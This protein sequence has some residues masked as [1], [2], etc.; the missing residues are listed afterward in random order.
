MPRTH[1]INPDNIPEPFHSLI[2]Y[3]ERWGISDDGYLDNAIDEAPLEELRELVKTVSEFK[4]DGFDEWLGNPGANNYTRDWVAF[5]CLIDA[6]DLAK[7]RLQSEN[8]NRSTD[9]EIVDE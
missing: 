9:V 2:P 4:A 6:C 7:F 1:Q 8:E 3:A 5:I